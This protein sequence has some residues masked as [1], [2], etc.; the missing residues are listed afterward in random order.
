M[1]KILFLLAGIL[2][3][4]GC[5]GTGGAGTIGKSVDYPKLFVAENLPQYKDA[6][7]V[8]IITDGP[9]LK[10]G[11]I[12]RLESQK[13]VKTIAKYYDEEMTKL[14]WTQPAI[15]EATENSYATQYEKGD[16]YLQFTASKITGTSQ[17]ITISLMQK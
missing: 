13:D 2:V 16:K 11:V 15:N 10:D 8:Q 5:G 9:T 17:T 7:L 1:K 3:L 4:A 12:L 14:G 6:K